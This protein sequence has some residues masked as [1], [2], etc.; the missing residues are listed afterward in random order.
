MGILFSDL[1]KK[2]FDTA[3]SDL[4]IF[5]TIVDYAGQPVHKGCESRLCHHSSYP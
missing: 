3:L 4:S 5:L 2:F 1:V